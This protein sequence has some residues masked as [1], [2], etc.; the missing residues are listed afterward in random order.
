MKKK[1]FFPHTP[2]PLVAC[3]SSFF[4][5]QLGGLGKIFLGKGFFPKNF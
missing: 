4:F 5:G 3:F 2:N 1:K